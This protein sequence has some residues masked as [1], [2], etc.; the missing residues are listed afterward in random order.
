MAVPLDIKH[1]IKK[2]TTFVASLSNTNISFL[3]FVKDNMNGT[4]FI[5]RVNTCAREWIL[6]N[7]PLY[8]LPG[9]YGDG[10]FY[11]YRENALKYNVY[12]DQQN[13]ITGFEPQVSSHGVFSGGSGT[14]LKNV[15]LGNHLTIGLQKS[16][17]T[18]KILFMTHKTIYVPN[19]DN[20]NEY[21]RDSIEC[22]VYLS[23]IFNGMCDCI[24]QGKP[25]GSKIQIYETIGNDSNAISIL[26]AIY[27]IIWNQ[28]AGNPKK[29]YRRKQKGGVINF[30]DQVTGGFVSSFVTFINN[31]VLNEIQT[32]RSDLSEAI[33]IDEGGDFIIIRYI[34]KTNGMD[35]SNLF[36]I[37]RNIVLDTWIAYTKPVLERSPVEIQ[38]IHSFITFIKGL[39]NV[40]VH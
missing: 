28:S 23:P 31:V 35:L 16:F 34:F 38:T 36:A 13:K 11:I 27:S 32:H 25:D 10:F 39:N 18:G 26:K 2:L 3:Y 22:N 8:F 15:T 33:V 5:P 29:K 19:M 9:V 7:E 20:P 4:G 12:F 14:V 21:Q 24:Q 40:L 6:E 30:K 37:K 1:Y 17:T